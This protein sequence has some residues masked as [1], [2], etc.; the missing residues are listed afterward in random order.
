MNRVNRT[1]FEVCGCPT[2]F[3][4]Y[5]AAAGSLDFGNSSDSPCREVK[6]ALHRRRA[7]LQFRETE[8]EYHK[9]RLQEWE[10]RHN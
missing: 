3:S 8:F 9:G 7:A 5:E 10:V 2:A 4:A 1:Q 6:I